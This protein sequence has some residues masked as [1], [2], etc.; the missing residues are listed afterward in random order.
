MESE[1][2]LGI[3]ASDEMKQYPWS[4]LTLNPLNEI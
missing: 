3:K 2:M 4:F 1:E